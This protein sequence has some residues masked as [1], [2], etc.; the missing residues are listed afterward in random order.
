MTENRYLDGA[1]LIAMILLSSWATSQFGQLTGRT[2]E[3][4]VASS[5]LTMAVVSLLFAGLAAL[6]F[7]FIDFI[8]LNKENNKAGMFLLVGALVGFL[9]TASGKLAL[10]N[11]LV[12]AGAINP[13]L[14]AV[15]VL[16]LAVFVET[17]FFWGALF[18]SIERFLGGRTNPLIATVAAALTVSF[19]FA[20][21]HIVATGGNE[22]RLTGEFLFSLLEIGLLKVTGSIAAPIG[23]HFAR[24]LITAG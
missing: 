10:V 8:G 13:T 6:G 7:G 21:W 20:T 12:G 3:A 4:F 2:Q 16:V 19:M 15:F 9:I 18:P 17:Y 5:Y 22:S 1:I 14:S 24:N 11:L 23:A